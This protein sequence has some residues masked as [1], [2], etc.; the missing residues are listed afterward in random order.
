MY[1]GFKHVIS[2]NGIAI[3]YNYAPFPGIASPTLGTVDAIGRAVPKISKFEFEEFV[4]A[5]CTACT[6]G[7]LSVSRF[8]GCSF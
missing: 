1:I 2:C 7:V 3:A 5:V 4:T 6:A 8:V